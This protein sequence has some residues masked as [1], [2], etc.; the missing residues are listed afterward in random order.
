MMVARRL[1][2]LLMP[3]E[4]AAAV[5]GA[6]RSGGALWRRCWRRSAAA[7]VPWPS[8]LPP[9]LVDLL[10]RMLAVKPGERL[11]MR[12]VMAHPYFDWVDWTAVAERRRDGKGAVA[13]PAVVAA[14]AEAGRVE[15]R[16]EAL[17]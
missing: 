6:I 1:A 15:E 9:L 11:T 13:L 10:S 5:L 8:S 7:R 16:E 12:Q 4:E 2:A 3:E 14:W 17:Q